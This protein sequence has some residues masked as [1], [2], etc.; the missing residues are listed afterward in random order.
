MPMV[1]ANV[2]QLEHC[3]YLWM[4]FT[5]QVFRAK[6]SIAE[7]VH[8]VCIRHDLFRAGAR[9]AHVCSVCYVL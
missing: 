7:S 2:S 1:R 4:A 6:K 8:F 5:V 9:S 3:G